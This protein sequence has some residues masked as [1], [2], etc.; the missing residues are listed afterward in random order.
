MITN[1]PTSE[2]LDR[3]ALRLFFSAWTSLAKVYEDFQITHVQYREWKSD[4]P[5]ESHKEEWSEYVTSCQPDL[6]S[7]Y[8]IIQQSQELALKA[9]IA[10]VS[11]Y[12]LLTLSDSRFSKIPKDIDF[13]SQR[14]LDAVDLPGAVN[15]YCSDT[16]SEQ[17]VQQYEKIRKQRNQITHLGFLNSQIQPGEV[18]PIL[19]NQFAELWPQRPWLKERRVF[20]ST[21]RLG[22]FHDGSN[23]SAEME[24]MHE[25]PYTVGMLKPA[26]FKLLFGKAKKTRRYVCPACIWE[27]DRDYADL[28]KYDCTTAFMSDDKT[29]IS[30]LMCEKTF[31]VTKAACTS[32]SCR[33]GLFCDKEEDDTGYCLSCGARQ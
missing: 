3:I 21:S 23:T 19:V 26:D 17:F 14:T 27:A 4:W 5:G 1:V 9:R 28:D 33:S 13:S 20:A 25:W 29:R 2:G 32:T 16:V 6:Q 10:N 30:C 12:L 24:V 15:T 18:F 8:T 11:P 7:I 22:F 31:L